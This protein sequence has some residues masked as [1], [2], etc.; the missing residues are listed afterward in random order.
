V[1]ARCLEFA[2]LTVTRSGE[3]LG[4]RWDEIDLESRVWSI[5][6]RRMKSAREHRVPLCNRALVILAEMGLLRDGDHVFPGQRCAKPLST[7]ALE[8]VMRRMGVKNATVHGFRS[9]FRDWAGNRT[10]FPRELAEHSLAHVMGDRA[11][12][13]PGATTSMSGRR[14]SGD[15]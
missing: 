10:T 9:C 3:A 1:A 5:P 13:A 15:S 7:M 6:A 4:A 11:E 8:M 14:C 12:Q 2:I